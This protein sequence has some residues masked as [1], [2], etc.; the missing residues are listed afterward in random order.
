MFF[1]HDIIL[2]TPKLGAIENIDY[3]GQNISYQIHIGVTEHNGETVSNKILVFRII[4]YRIRNNLSSY[5]W[6][7]CSDASKHVNFQL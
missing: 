6:K 7:K 1:E 3:G 4:L 2:E 5:P